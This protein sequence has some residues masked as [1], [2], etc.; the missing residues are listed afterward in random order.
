VP[1]VWNG[2]AGY[3]SMIV[4]GFYKS[5]KLLYNNLTRS[6]CRLEAQGLS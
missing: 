4:F 3:S 2:A 6:I 1:V 5:F